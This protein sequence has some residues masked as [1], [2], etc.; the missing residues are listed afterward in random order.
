MH[1]YCYFYGKYNVESDDKIV[2]TFDRK[3]RDKE[4]CELCPYYINQT[5]A[6]NII[7]RIAFERGLT[8]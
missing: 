3:K 1:K 8:K 2:C 7:R 6:D 4:I 5:E